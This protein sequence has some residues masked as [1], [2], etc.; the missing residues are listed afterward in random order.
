MYNLKTIVL[1]IILI[2]L[3]INIP[4][5]G[6]DYPKY[7]LWNIITKFYNKSKHTYFKV[8][9]NKEV[10]YESLSII[11]DIFKKHNVFF[12]LSEGTALGFV[13]GN[14]FISHDDDLDISIFE[15]DR[16]KLKKALF[17]LCKNGFTVDYMRPYK[18]TIVCLSRNGENI[19]ID[20]AGIN[21]NCVACW[22][23]G[24]GSCHCKHLLPYLKKFNK[25]KIRGK[26]YNVPTTKYLEFLYDK[27]WRTPIKNKKP[28]KN[29]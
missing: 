8:P 19:D 20:V 29:Y 13:R 1:L 15:K 25:L 22:S 5:N 4:W 21:N 27:D 7:K 11:H 16:E 14:D 24:Q 9:L 26:I 10:C 12:W 3:F 2:I 18:P 6:N 17:E 23:S 28:I